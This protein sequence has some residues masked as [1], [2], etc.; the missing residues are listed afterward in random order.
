MP[1]P[2]AVLI[3][4]SDFDSFPPG[5]Q[6]TMAR[7]LMKLFGDR[8]ALVG[9]TTGDEPTGSWTKKEISGTSYWFFP[10]CHRKPSPKKPL[11]PARLEFYAGLRR[12]KDRILSLDCRAAFLQ[13]PEALLAVSSWRWDSLCFWFAGVENPLTRSRY[14]YAAPFY[15]FFD[16][17]FFSALDRVDILLAAADE[18]AINQLVFRS[19]GRL[20][21]DRLYQ[22]P[23]CVDT[24]EFCP[25]PARTA[26]TKLEIPLDCKVFVNTGRIGRF[27]GWEL[28]VDAFDEFR[29]K[30]ND[31]LLFFV[32]DGEDRPTLEKHIFDRNLRAQVRITGFLKP[33]QI[34]SYLNAAN[35]VV[36]GS[37]VEGWS[38]SMLEALACGKAIVSTPVSGTDAMI[39]PGQNGFIVNGRNPAS[40]A[41]AMENA[42]RLD[43]AGH[44]SR[45]IAAQFDLTRLGERL[46]SFWAPLRPERA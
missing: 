4:G 34:V 33:T 30:N 23:T 45:S 9:M 18:P 13:S 26:R 46:G 8:L 41:E 7:S 6:L 5:G 10:A 43:D 11:I 31:A 27:K 24:S 1:V 29:R 14:W 44:V 17:S 32:G 39:I 42:L 16:K 25:A 2:A 19:H 38:V 28:L 20:A 21:H 15:R 37:L 12:Y 35:A 3:E 22:L 40:F 36:F